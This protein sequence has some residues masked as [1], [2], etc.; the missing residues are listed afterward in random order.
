M[1]K[2]VKEA[3]GALAKAVDKAEQRSFGARVPR[4]P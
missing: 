4:P 3:V 1:V 2:I